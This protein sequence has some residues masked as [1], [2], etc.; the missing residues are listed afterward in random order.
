MWYLLLMSTSV[1]HFLTSIPPVLPFSDG[2]VRA[3][4]RVG[5]VE[6]SPGMWDHLVLGRPGKQEPRD[7]WSSDLYCT[8]QKRS[9]SDVTCRC[10][11][12]RGEQDWQAAML[13]P[14]NWTWERGLVE[15]WCRHSPEQQHWSPPCAGCIL[16]RVYPL[17]SNCTP[18]KGVLS[19]SDLRYILRQAS[20]KDVPSHY[21]FLSHNSTQLRSLWPF[22]TFKRGE[23]SGKKRKHFNLGMSPKPF[24]NFGKVKCT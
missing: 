20:K 22:V 5:G 14:L 12:P 11:S 17:L 21:N 9:F 3:E 18:P 1:W 16:C 6:Y 19:Q 23:Y 24:I 2:C 7:S 10:L 15:C 4:W 8:W 13:V